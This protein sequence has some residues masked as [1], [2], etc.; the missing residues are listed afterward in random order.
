VG[1]VPPHPKKKQAKA[2][3][4]HLRR[5]KKPKGFDGCPVSPIVHAVLSDCREHLDF[6]F[7]IISA[8]RRDGVAQKFGHSSQLQLWNL[9]QH[10]KGLPANPP[11][12]STHEYKNGGTSKYGTGTPAYHTEFKVGATLPPWALGLDFAS[13]DQATEFIGHAKDL[14]YHFFQ[15]Y[16]SGS[17][18][19]HLCIAVNPLE[20]LIKR[21]RA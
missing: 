5:S 1:A 17:E 3:R 9:F 12:T 2:H 15:P 16:N 10:G 7:Q 19:H 13:N 14:G 8:D 20:N 18:L 6:K 11:L 4:Q 21:N